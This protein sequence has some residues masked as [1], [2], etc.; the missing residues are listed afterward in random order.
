MILA[1]VGIRTLI[2]WMPLPPQKLKIVFEIIVMM[3]AAA[4]VKITANLNF[5]TLLDRIPKS[6]T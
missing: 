2:Q 4:Y 1:I 3:G 5:C 6:A